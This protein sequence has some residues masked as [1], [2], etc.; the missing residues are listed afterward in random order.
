MG[1]F[2]L[3][4]LKERPANIT[5]SITAGRFC[6]GFCVL[7]HR[8]AP[9]LPAIFNACVL[10]DEKLLMSPEDGGEF[11]AMIRVCGFGVIGTILKSKLKAR[12]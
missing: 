5:H 3:K 10:Y 2:H 11:A 9:F 4:T 12:M 1:L 6:G 7:V 8:G